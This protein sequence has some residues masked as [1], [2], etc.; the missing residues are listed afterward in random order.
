MSN[1][2]FRAIAFVMAR[3]PKYS[4]GK[5]A[6]NVGDFPWIQIHNTS[7]NEAVV[8][9]SFAMQIVW[10]VCKLNRPGQWWKLK[11]KIDSS[12]HVET[13]YSRLRLKDGGYGKCTKIK[14][15]PYRQGLQNAQKRLC[16]FLLLSPSS[17]RKLSYLEISTTPEKDKVT[18]KCTTVI[19]L[20]LSILLAP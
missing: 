20:L 7:L 12:R 9:S 6:R 18:W 1:Y 4:L 16:S 5:A 2:V 11:G 19:I 8:P 10:I 15:K 14:T 13:S 3:A 17:F